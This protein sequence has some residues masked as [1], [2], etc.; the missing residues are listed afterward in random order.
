MP[1]QAQGD[2][3]SKAMGEAATPSMDLYGKALQKEA[4]SSDSRLCHFKNVIFFELSSLQS[5][6]RN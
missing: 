3:L 6:C 4:E 5:I 1:S 2:R